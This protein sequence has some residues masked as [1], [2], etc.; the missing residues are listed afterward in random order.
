MS[1]QQ[2]QTSTN[3]QGVAE[4]L[5]NSC[6]GCTKLALV[7]PRLDLLAGGLVT[8]LCSTCWD[9]RA[10][11]IEPEPARKRRQRAG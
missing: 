4:G 9:E 7:Y 11:G 6:D 1:K 2:Q 8:W 10:K 5:S 3:W